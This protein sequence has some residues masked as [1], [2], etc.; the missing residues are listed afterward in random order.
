[1]NNLL[2]SRKRA[3]QLKALRGGLMIQLYP[4]QPIGT[5]DEQGNL[6][7]SDL[8]SSFK[9]YAGNQQTAY[10]N[11]SVQTSSTSHV[12]QLERQV[13]RAISQVLG[14]SP[15]RGATNFFNA[16]NAAFPRTNDDKLA[17]LPSQSQMVLYST[18]GKGK[19]LLGEL[20][21]QQA[22]L[23]RQ[24]SIIMADALKIIERLSSFIPQADTERVEALRS[25]ITSQ[26]KVLVE[27][28]RWVDEPRPAR[29]E[30]YLRSLNDNVAE[31]GRQAFLNNPMLAVNINDEDQITQYEL[32]KTYIQ[33]LEQA[34]N[35]YA[36]SRA[37]QISSLSERIDRARVLLPVLSQG[38]T[39][40]SNALESVGLSDSERRSRASRFSILTTSSIEDGRNPQTA[41]NLSLWLP[42]ITV[43][44]LIDWLDRFANMEAPSNLDNTYGI[45]FVTDQ[46]DRL[47]WT[48]API[49]AHLKI[50]TPLNSSSR[51]TLE[52]IL[53][54]ER[55]TW[56]L[57]NLL[58]QLNELANLAV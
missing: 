50:W 12:N 40:F 13:E 32:L 7:L 34:W 18:D 26:I 28:F 21:T 2:L 15:G 46:A 9:R 57:D 42:D 8:L 33:M 41:S 3:Q 20:S 11:G 24:A 53:S 14:R 56:A 37:N 16:L 30:A 38:N 4:T 19:E 23:Y 5:V 29:V 44:D 10:D 54:N 47:F 45:D 52:Q 55:V 27:E 6:L 51:S 25:L 35:R 22:A 49:V 17:T 48:I 43:S 36:S 39:D 1:M 58:N 31:F